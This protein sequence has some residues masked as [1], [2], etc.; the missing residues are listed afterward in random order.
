MTSPVAIIDIGTTKTCALVAEKTERGILRV[1]GSGVAP[2]RGLR[3]GVVVDVNQTSESIAQA[4]AQAQ[5]VSGFDVESAL[6][7]V[8]GTHIESANSRGVATIHG[9]RAV[10]QADIDRALES[11]EEIVVPEN[12]ELIHSIPRGYTLD[13]Q[14]GIKEPMGMLGFKLEVEAH[15]ATGAV[16]PIQNLIKAVES[17]GVSASDLVFS[18]IASGDAVLTPAEKEMG[19]IVVDIGGGTTDIAV[20]IDGSVWHTVVLP[21]GGLNVTN[22]LAVG[23]RA[24]FE[25]AEQIKVNYGRMDVDAIGE[26]QVLD[27]TSFGE[28]GHRP[29]SRRLMAEVIHAR[30]EEILHMILT[31]IKRSGYDNLLP[32]GVV[33]CGGTA[34]VPGLRAFA[35]EIFQM[36]VRIGAPREIEGFVDRVSSPASATA[37]GLLH[38]G[39]RNGLEAEGVSARGKQS[40]PNPLDGLVVW[41]RRAL[42]P[43]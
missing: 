22:D 26:D 40:K 9:G 7:S 42:L 43:G 2:S 28:D 15:I 16:P 19:V 3:K 33:L 20:F 30:V 23:L 36:P 39:F 13:G 38:W 4:L 1:L 31:E 12:R 6:V 17:A 5:R 25:A 41:A 8:T 32:A 14:D 37:I 34:S 10:S 29:I 11:A 27:V 35:R 24:P 18:P 21:I